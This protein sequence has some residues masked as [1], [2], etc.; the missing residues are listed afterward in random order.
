MKKKGQSIE[1]GKNDGVFWMSYSDFFR[2]FHQLFLCKFFSENEY[3]EVNYTSEWKAYK[4][5]AGGC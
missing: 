3:A 4:N 2:H 5:T 1:I